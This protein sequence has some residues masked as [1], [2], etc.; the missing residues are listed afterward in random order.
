MQSILESIPARR[1]VL[2]LLKQTG[3]SNT[4][5]LE[6]VAAHARCSSDFAVDVFTRLDIHQE[7]GRV[8]LSSGR[9]L[10]LAMGTARTGSVVEAGR[11]LAWQEFEK[12]AEQCLDEMGYETMRDLRVKGDGR[13][14]QI[15]LVGMKS[16][17]VLCFDCKHWSAHSS[18]SRFRTAEEH[19]VKA[20]GIVV[21]K[22]SRE[23]RKAIH[24]LPIILTLFDPPT[25]LSKDVVVLSVQRL[26]GLLAELT[27]YSADLPFILA[28][29]TQRE[30]LIK[31][32]PG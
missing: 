16:A 4:A 1:L 14:W 24:G 19:Q 2:E 21:R 20:T 11:Y 8:S 15:D 28:E 7:N 30:N 17:L 23:A 5:S 25:S 18:P 10:V 6:V 12:F 27:P 26:P 29:E 13:N 22:I 9:R 31:Q 32:T 3:S